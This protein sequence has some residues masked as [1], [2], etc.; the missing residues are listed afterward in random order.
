MN[1]SSRPAPGR[2]AEPE[3]EVYPF[4]YV[5]AGGGAGEMS[6]GLTFMDSSGET[7]RREVAARE[8]GIREGELRA[9]AGYEQ[10]LA[11]TRENLRMAL[12]G[13]AKERELY[14]QRVEDEVVRLALSI[15]RKVLQREANTDPLL[16]AALV[17]VA[18]DKI[19]SKTKVIVRVHPQ[20]SEDCRSFFTRCMD[21]QALPEI[22]EDTSVEFDHCILQTEL[23]S[24]EL[25]IEPQL[26]E[27]DKGLMDL[28]AQRPPGS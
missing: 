28:L 26:Q 21:P 13:F 17:R 24:A 14:Y 22:I 10:H 12:A 25:G 1:S 8:A 23:G 7:L 18:L 11:D 2:E 19:E 3:P 20:Q 16:L 27:I 15:A 4:P 9:R 6:G 5:N